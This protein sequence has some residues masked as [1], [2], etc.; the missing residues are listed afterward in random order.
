MS[1]KNLHTI[2][3]DDND[4]WWER[5]RMVKILEDHVALEV[6]IIPCS[7]VRFLELT[8]DLTID[9]ALSS[10]PP[11]ESRRCRRK[12]RKLRRKFSRRDP[13]GKL[14]KSHLQSKVFQEIREKAHDLYAEMKMSNSSS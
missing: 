14:S 3:Q 13:K 7:V 11:E 6:G 2:Y 8:K 12:F 4:D 1:R 9:K 10:M 5:Q